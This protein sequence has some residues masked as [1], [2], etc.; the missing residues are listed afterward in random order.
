MSITIVDDDTR[1]AYVD[2]IKRVFVLARVADTTM[3]V[4]KISDKPSLFVVFVQILWLSFL[5]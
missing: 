4:L 5:T 2:T 1:V 3:Y